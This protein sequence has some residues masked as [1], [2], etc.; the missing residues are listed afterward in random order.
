VR[1]RLLAIALALALSPIL[2]TPAVAAEPAAVE[3]KPSDLGFGPRPQIAWYDA[4]QGRIER[5]AG[6]AIPARPGQLLR[7]RGGWITTTGATAVTVTFISDAGRKRVLH[8]PS[9]FYPRMVS[10]D[11]RTVVEDRT[12]SDGHGLGDHLIRVVRVR[13]GKVLRTRTFRDTRVEVQA[14]SAAAAVVRVISNRPRP[15]TQV[16]DQRNGV[17]RLLRRAAPAGYTEAGFW[18][19]FVG[20]GADLARDRVVVREGRYDVVRDV[21][22]GERLWQGTAYES[23]YRFS[24]DGRTVLTLADRDSVNQGDSAARAV[25]LRDAS[26]GEVRAT[27]T[28]VFA[29]SIVEPTWE[30]SSAVLLLAADDRGEDPDEGEGYLDRPSLVRCTLDGRC[31]RVRFDHRRGDMLTVRPGT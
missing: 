17:L 2:A 26:T 8:R 20:P 29:E 31:E 13:D 18:P 22:T 4:R 14:L 3:V 15:L 5:P 16:W 27:F 24:P 12:V 21:G 7:A 30:S 1:T 23:L 11:G 28:G 6:P 10:S 25:R 9:P 19:E